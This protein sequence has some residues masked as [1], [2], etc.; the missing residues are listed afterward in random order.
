MLPDKMSKINNGK[1]DF[2]FYSAFYAERIYTEPKYKK[3]QPL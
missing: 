3:T 2:I 1:Y